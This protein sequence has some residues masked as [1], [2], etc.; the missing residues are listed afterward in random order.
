MPICL[1]IR[2]FKLIFQVNNQTNNKISKQ[3]LYGDT[4]QLY[5]LYMYQLRKKDYF[6][7]IFVNY[8]ARAKIN[9][10]GI[11]FCCML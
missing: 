1:I 5:S 8:N 4:V 3:I 10:Q 9:L 2:T 6:L 11:S 7:K